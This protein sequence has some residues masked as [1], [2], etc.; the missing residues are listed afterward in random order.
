MPKALILDCSGPS[1]TAEE[2]AFFAAA[3]PLGFI[4]FARHIETPDQV[5]ALVRELRNAVG[6][7]DAPVL[8]DQEGG[9]VQR[10]K[11]PHW[12]AAPP[13]EV[14]GRLAE[15]DLAKAR[16]AVYLN[17][18][19]LAAELASL[20][21]TVDCAP[22]VDLRHPGAHDVI[23]NRAFG[24]DPLLVADLGRAAMDGLMAGGVQP[25]VKHIPG[26]GRAL[27]DSHL[28]LP[29]CDTP[30]AAL[31]G[32]DFLPFRLLRDAPWAMTA[33]VLYSDI[34]PAAPATTSR[35]L[36]EEVIR[37]QLGFD[38][39]L[40]SDDLSMRA[41]A[42]DPAEHAQAAQAAG[43]DILLLCNASLE[44]RRAV[45]AATGPL[46]AQAARRLTAAAAR[47]QAAVETAA[48]L[49]GEGLLRALDGLLAAA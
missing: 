45:A 11:P 36:V 23:G 16:E 40:I 3:D 18:R 44:E 42:G 12:R 2:R 34:D 28:E 9:R 7:P 25:I 33:H 1:L 35:R 22:V 15:R 46:S 14:F 27:V 13:A 10:L 8:I 47:C 4:L 43:C 41:L 37:G 20:G 17:H 49:D 48:P 24:G 39:L 26:H 21:I 32:S 5:R 31:A 19:L 29:R 30:A 38:G 6:R